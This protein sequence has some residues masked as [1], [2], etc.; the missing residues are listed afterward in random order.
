MEARG[1][2]D[3]HGS[4][5][6]ALDS[7]SDLKVHDVRS[8]VSRPIW[9]Q[10]NN[11]KGHV[12]QPSQDSSE[13]GSSDR[14]LQPA[15]NS[16]GRKPR[17]VI[18][19]VAGASSG[20]R[21]TAS[22]PSLNRNAG[23][24]EEGF[25][26]RGRRFQGDTP[27][28]SGAAA[29]IHE[30]LPS[31]KASN[32]P[33]AVGR[34]RRGKQ[35]NASTR[36]QPYLGAGRDNVRESQDSLTFFANRHAGRLGLPVGKQLVGKK[37]GREAELRAFGAEDGGSRLGSAPVVGQVP[38]DGANGPPAAANGRQV[39]SAHGHPDQ[40]FRPDHQPFV[41]PSLPSGR[42]LRLDIIST[43]GDPHYVG[44]SGIEL[45]AEKGHPIE[46]SAEAISAEPADIN[47]LPGYGNDPRTIDK[48]VD[49]ANRT[50]DDLHVW[51][52]PYTAG[53]HHYVFIDLGRARTISMIRIWNYNKSRI[54]SYRG[55]RYIELLLD[56]R[57]IFKGEIQK[58]PGMLQGAEA[59][60][61]NILFTMDDEVLCAIEAHDALDAN[62]TPSAGEDQTRQPTPTHSIPER[63]KTAGR[64]G[65]GSSSRSGGGVGDSQDLSS[66]QYAAADAKVEGPSERLPPQVVV[67]ETGEMSPERTEE[68]DSP[69]TPNPNDVRPSLGA[70]GRP[71]TR[72]GSLCATLH[73]HNR[74]AF[75]SATASSCVQGQVLTLKLL[76]NW[77]DLDAIGM[78]G[79][80]I[81]LADDSVF[82]VKA[83][84]ISVRCEDTLRDDVNSS[85]LSANYAL[86]LFSGG[87]GSKEKTEM[88][89]IPY[90]GNRYSIC[91]D[92]QRSVSLSGLRVWNYN[93]SLEGSYRGVKRLAIA[94][95]DVNISPPVG[96]LIRKAPGPIVQDYAQHIKFQASLGGAAIE[97][98]GTPQIFFGGGHSGVDVALVQEYEPPTLPSGF[99]FKFVLLST[100]DDR[101]YM[102]LNGL[103][104]YDHL[105]RPVPIKASVLRAACAGGTTSVAD[106]QDCKGDPRTLDKL[107]DDVN[108]TTDDRH[109]WLAPYERGE[110]NNMFIMFEEPVTLSLLKLWN[111]TKSPG[112]GVREF[113]LC[114]DDVLVYKGHVR[115]AGKSGGDRSLEAA[116]QS[117]L[118][119]HDRRVVAR[120]RSNVYCHNQ[121]SEV[122]EM[123]FIDDPPPT[124]GGDSGRLEQRPGTSVVLR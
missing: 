45:F 124:A 102:G 88:W 42:H 12:E 35:D 6:E 117:I 73:P 51:L 109:M 121:Q 18:G 46:L 86:S 93:S 81:L 122:D 34:V 9:L 95:D 123:V 118:F 48:L 11:D 64:M 72:A 2:S 61:E 79:V 115:Q 99:V 8:K 25:G 5:N 105:D 15:A 82:E 53:R 39:L 26:L 54:H 19:N 119:T 68:S 55:A 23:D 87:F 37:T 22:I 66:W 13:S 33:P 17:V 43:W 106:L 52:A 3:D 111:Y 114:I 76:S 7:L 94:L 58:A 83:D 60:A 96:H 78:C 30:D 77:G 103:Q 91:V 100:W 24:G 38:D 47:I 50:C 116:G 90:A 44:L 107:V 84:M 75:L 74:P 71:M 10:N 98:V 56:E 31:P 89:L 57:P 101:F 85:Y 4:D 92:M 65:S 14:R 28:V 1:D 63:P 120:E 112:R 62:I 110:P 69:L 67:S 36:I 40:M 70:D 80:E 27:S 21:T 32:S 16:A 104:L 97:R 20:T 49:G 29:S 108:D 113:Q 59:Y 41:I